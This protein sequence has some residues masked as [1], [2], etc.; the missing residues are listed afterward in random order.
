M[1]KAVFSHGQ[2]YVAFSRVRAID[3]VKLKVIY[4]HGKQCMLC[5]KSTDIFTKNI[6][7][8]EIFR[9]NFFLFII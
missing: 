8:K 1:P 7:Y 2:V 9:L 4:E 6:V 3:D 5:E